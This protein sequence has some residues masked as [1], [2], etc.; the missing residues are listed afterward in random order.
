MK[1][2]KKLQ[3]AIEAAVQAGEIL[4]NSYNENLNPSVKESLRDI[5]TEADK[6]AEKSIIDILT[7]NDSEIAIISEETNPINVTD[8]ETYWTIDALDGTVN[9]LN[10]IPFFSVSIS[11]VENNNL[12][13]GVIY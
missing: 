1:N 8:A 3:L 9:Y 4:I 12:E 2:E 11:Y 6:S 13:I 7:K 5:V 10:H